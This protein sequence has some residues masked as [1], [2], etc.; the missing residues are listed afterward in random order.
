MRKD[1]INNNVNMLTQFS[2]NIYQEEINKKLMI[3]I[4]LV[5]DVNHFFLC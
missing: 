5:N 2:N 3:N 4:I 1:K